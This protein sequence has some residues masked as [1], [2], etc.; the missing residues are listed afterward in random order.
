MLRDSIK[1]DCQSCHFLDKES[2]NCSKGMNIVKH[3]DRLFTLGYCREYVHI[4]KPDIK[5]PF[6]FDLFLVFDEDMNTEDDLLQ[7]IQDTD[8][9]ARKRIHV[10]DISMNRTKNTSLQFFKEHK[11]NLDIQ[12]HCFL[13]QPG[14][15]AAIFDASKK[16]MNSCN[17][18]VVLPAGR[19]VDADG[20]EEDAI[21]KKTKVL[22]WNFPIVLEGDE[23]IVLL[24]TGLYIKQPFLRLAKRDE[25][26]VYTLKQHELETGM[27]LSWLI[28]QNE[29]L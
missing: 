21:S 16:L 28:S 18:F 23:R 10:L 15:Y 29:I 5:V 7:S 13:D 3:R 9:N 2:G 27:Q 20:L 12:V 26:Y 1:T 19:S 14:P 6:S 4:K 11:D 8:S 22:H 17:Y 24:Y 25:P